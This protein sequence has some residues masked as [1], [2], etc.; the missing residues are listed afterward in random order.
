MIVDTKP[1][2]V[3]PKVVCLPWRPIELP[4][5]L[6]FAVIKSN[7]V[8]NPLPPITRGLTTTIEKLKEAGHEILEWELSDQNEI[9][10]LSVPPPLESA[11]TRRN[12]ILRQGKRR[13]VHYL[14]LLG[15]RFQK[16]YECYMRIQYKRFRQASYGNFKVN[17]LL[18]R[19][20]ILIL[21]ITRPKRRNLVVPLTP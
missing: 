5:Q 15:N 18:L 19:N 10:Q 13:L 20:Y 8:V 14:K 3:D 12:F 6:S 1:W 2:L 11:K 4:S 9:A 17:G 16:G 7:N 21:G